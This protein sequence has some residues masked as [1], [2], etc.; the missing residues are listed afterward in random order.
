MHL[1]IENIPFHQ[2]GTACGDKYWFL[3]WCQSNTIIH[4][5]SRWQ[6]GWWSHSNRDCS[7]MLTPQTP[8]RKLW[9]NNCV[10]LNAFYDFM[11]AQRLNMSWILEVFNLSCDVAHCTHIEL[12]SRTVTSFSTTEPH[13]AALTHSSFTLEDSGAAVLELRYFFTVT[14]VL[15]HTTLKAKMELQHV[16]MANN[17]FHLFHI[18]RKKE[19]NHGG[20][21]IN[22]LPG[23][24]WRKNDSLVV[25]ACPWSSVAWNR[26]SAV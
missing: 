24:N 19:R 26:L 25:E 17:M 16:I 5:F 14:H 9:M 10:F 6:P 13:C 15:H 21:V 1:F 12:W 2:L 20:C 18:Q 3:A 7:N 23:I 4:I 11:C 22:M 8:H